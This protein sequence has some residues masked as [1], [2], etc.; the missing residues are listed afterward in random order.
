MHTH[1]TY[2]PKVALKFLLDIDSDDLKN[3][4][5]LEYFDYDV[6]NPPKRVSSELDRRSELNQTS[7]YDSPKSSL[8]SFSFS[9]AATSVECSEQSIYDSPRSSSDPNFTFPSDV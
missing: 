6:P 7:I 3:G 1:L 9:L 5:N 4:D 2:Y 8:K